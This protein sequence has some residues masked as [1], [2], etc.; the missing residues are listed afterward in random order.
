LKP[1]RQKKRE[2]SKKRSSSLEFYLEAYENVVL[3]IDP[4]SCL[5]NA[6]MM[7]ALLSILLAPRLKILR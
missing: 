7:T 3:K 4:L 5:K 6:H 1:P 2:N